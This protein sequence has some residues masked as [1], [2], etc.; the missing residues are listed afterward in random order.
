MGNYFLASQNAILQLI[1]DAI[2]YFPCRKGICPYF[3]PLIRLNI[4]FQDAVWHSLDRLRQEMTGLSLRQSRFSLLS[5]NNLKPIQRFLQLMPPGQRTNSPR[6]SRHLLIHT[7]NSSQRKGF[8]PS[9][10]FQSWCLEFWKAL[11]SSNWHCWDYSCFLVWGI[12][13]KTIL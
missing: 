5:P 8:W 1:D 11:S 9:L 6:L 12:P 13:I 3:Q 4:L 2:Q 10:H 7:T